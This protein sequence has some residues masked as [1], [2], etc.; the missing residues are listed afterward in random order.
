MAMTPDE[1]ADSFRADIDEL[2]TL[3]PLH[4]TEGSVER[5][6]WDRKAKLLH[7]ILD[8][9]KERADGAG[10]ISPMSGGEPKPQ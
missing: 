6:W 3:I 7:L 5:R 10:M 2:H 4:T 1:L 9:M 8:E